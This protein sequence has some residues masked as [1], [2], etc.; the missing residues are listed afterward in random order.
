MKI[1]EEIKKLAV[2]NNKNSGLLQAYQ[3]VPKL[4]AAARP[5]AKK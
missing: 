1:T 3:E 5:E 4:D 2:K